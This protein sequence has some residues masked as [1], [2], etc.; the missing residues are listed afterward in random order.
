MKAI[1]LKVKYTRLGIIADALLG[2]ADLCG[3]KVDITGFNYER[4]DDY[5][6]RMSIATEL[7]YKIQEQLNKRYPAETYKIPLEYHHAT[8]L[9]HALLIYVGETKDDFKRNAIEI[10]KNELNAE[11]VNLSKTVTP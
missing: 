6:I 5:K 7:Y 9:Q 8:I 10:V 3:I 11:I 1:K 4:R 2:Y